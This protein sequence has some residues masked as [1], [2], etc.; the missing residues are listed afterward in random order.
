[1][2]VSLSRDRVSQLLLL[3]LNFTLSSSADTHKSISLVILSILF[4]ISI[5]CLT[6]G[7]LASCECKEVKVSSV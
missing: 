4:F 2:W 5:A 1:M 7:L 3:D 6:P